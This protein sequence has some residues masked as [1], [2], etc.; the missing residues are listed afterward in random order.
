MSQDTE[1]PP[2]ITINNYQL[3]VG[4]EFTYLSSTVTENL[5][6][7]SE[8]SRRI[9]RATSTLARLSKRVFDNDKLTMNTKMT[10]YRACVLSALLYGSES[11]TVYSRQERR[12]NTFHMR[13]VTRILSIKWSDHITNNEAL[14]RAATPIIYTLLR[15]RRLRWQG[16]VCRMQDGRIPRDLLHDELTT[17]KTA[18]GRPQLRLKTVCKRDT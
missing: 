11:W 18:Q 8:I 6:M 14:R 1:G 7:D 16:H 13:N 5:F 3:D 9:G 10:V 15:Q 12:L 17:G 4:K 2:T